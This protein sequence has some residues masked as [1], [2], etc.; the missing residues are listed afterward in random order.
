MTQT[1]TLG[2]QKNKISQIV[3]TIFATKQKHV[4]FYVIAKKAVDILFK[5]PIDNI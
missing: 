4:F 5:K 3:G 1:R 2:G